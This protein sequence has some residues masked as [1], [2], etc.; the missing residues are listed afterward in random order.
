MTWVRVKE[1][2]SKRWHAIYHTWGQ[3]HI[4]WCG[5]FTPAT[6]PAITDPLKKC[7][8]CASRMRHPYLVPDEMRRLTGERPPLQL[9]LPQ[10][11]AEGELF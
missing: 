3:T 7:Q 4:T 11:S 8:G 5:R 1:T 9:S 6:S 2:G 10:E